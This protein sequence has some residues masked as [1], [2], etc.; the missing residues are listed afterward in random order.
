M[1]VAVEEVAAVD[2][3]ASP[4]QTI[5]AAI[6]NLQPRVFADAQGHGIDQRETD[7]I[8]GEGL[9]HIAR[10]KAVTDGWQPATAA[11]IHRANDRT[12]RWCYCNRRTRL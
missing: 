9:E 11:G 7:A 4:G 1:A 8:A 6:Y 2:I 12:D 3:D 10:V 5:V